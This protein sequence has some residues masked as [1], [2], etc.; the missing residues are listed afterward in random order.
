[1]AVTRY[2]L[3]AHDWLNLEYI[4]NDLTRRVVTQN[5]GP[6]SSPTFEDVTITGLSGSI[7]SSESVETS[8]EE[9]DTT[10]ATL[11]DGSQYLLLDGTRAM[12]GDLDMDGYNIDNCN[13]VDASSGKILTADGGTSQPTVESDGYVGVAEVSSDG[14]LYFFVEGVRYYVSGTKDLTGIPM[15]LLL[16]LTY[17]S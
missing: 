4:I 16:S 1:V 13:I 7:I 12:E 8:I 10:L 17:S 11:G 5:L 14:R 2:S 3:V 9:L 15:G 6:T